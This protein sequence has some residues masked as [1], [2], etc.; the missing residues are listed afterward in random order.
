MAGSWAWPRPTELTLDHPHATVTVLEKED[1]V[2]AHQ[3][4][5]NSGVIHAGVYYKPGSLKA[6]AVPGRRQ[7]R[8][9]SSARRTASR[10][11]SAASSSWP[12]TAAELPRLH[13]LSERATANGLPVTHDR[14][15]RRPRE[16]EPHVACVAAL[17]VASTGIVDYAQVAGRLADLVDEGRRHGPPRR[18]GDR[19][20]PGRRGGRRRRPRS[21]RSGPTI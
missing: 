5:H 9:S 20:A 21:A 4:G 17:H 3:T 8:W 19:P 16:Y 6:A 12:P 14:P 18:P 2:A 7:R 1:R 15:G 11:R 13:A 10:T